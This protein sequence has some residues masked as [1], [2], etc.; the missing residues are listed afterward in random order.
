M[1]GSALLVS[2][3][4]TPGVTT[5]ETALP[6]ASNWYTFP[7]LKETQ[8]SYSHV[9]DASLDHP[10][11]V[12]QRGGS[13]IPR[14]TRARRSTSS[15]R[16]DPFTL[17]VAPDA[18]SKATGSL[19]IDDGATNAHLVG[20]WNRAE[21]AWAASASGG[22]LTFTAGVAD[23]KGRV[24]QLSGTGLVVERVF[25]AM[26]AQPSRV[27][28]QQQHGGV[29]QKDVAFTFKSGVVE[30]RSHAAA[31]ACILS[32]ITSNVPSPRLTTSSRWSRRHLL[33]RFIH[34]R[35]PQQ[36]QQPQHTRF[37]QAA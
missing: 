2:P 6:V 8:H 29:G 11:P 27:V 24:G 25:V 4:V 36:Q 18:S 22:V 15:Q 9:Q 28:L 21:L 37:L 13:I 3:I 20:Q 16:F 30:V 33:S 5:L 23:A 32:I 19:Y 34:E 1:L 10:L 14:R 17:N 35:I 31:R 7:D 26:A 12:F